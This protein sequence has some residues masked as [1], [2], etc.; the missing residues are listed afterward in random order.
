MEEPAS[1]KTEETQKVQVQEERSKTAIEVSEGLR[2]EVEVV[3]EFAVDAPSLSLTEAHGGIVSGEKSETKEQSPQA[4]NSLIL[5]GIK[6]DVDS[7]VDS[8]QLTEEVPV[9]P[10]P[11]ASAEKLKDSS[12]QVEAKKDDVKTFPTSNGTNHPDATLVTDVLNRNTAME[13]TLEPV[14]SSDGIPGSHASGLVSNTVDDETMMPSTVR[15]EAGFI[16]V[17]RDM[18]PERSEE[19]VKPYLEENTGESSGGLGDNISTESP[20]KSLKAE[21]GSSDSSP[22]NTGANN[23]PVVSLN[24]RPE[25]PTS[26]RSCCGL[27]EVLRRPHA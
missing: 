19:K 22:E 17:A 5:D 7:N 14:T 25:H 20:N 1:V 2:H 6:E 21:V 13:T 23:P 27:F 16:P 18:D 11:E 24:R 9:S 4:D 8:T 10:E 3:G 26:W 12:S 15:K